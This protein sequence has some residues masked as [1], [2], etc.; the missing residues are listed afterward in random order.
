M[1]EAGE[2]FS[3][4]GGSSIDDSSR[5]E[6]SMGMG[7]YTVDSSGSSGG[8][9]RLSDADVESKSTGVL[10]ARGMSQVENCH[11]IEPLLLTASRYSA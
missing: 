2:T 11:S 5:A 9:D 4:V 6:S 8:L 3:A 10:S 7:S 1:I